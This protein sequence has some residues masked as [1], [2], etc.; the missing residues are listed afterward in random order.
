MK[1]SLVLNAYFM[2]AALTC[3]NGKLH[4]CSVRKI[5]ISPFNSQRLLR[6]RNVQSLTEDI[7]LLVAEAGFKPGLPMKPRCSHCTSLSD[8]TVKPERASS[9]TVHWIA[10]YTEEQELRSCL[11]NLLS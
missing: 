8:N 11:Y 7:Y 3:F 10:P 4:D 6:F 5:L 2:S 9:E 1:S